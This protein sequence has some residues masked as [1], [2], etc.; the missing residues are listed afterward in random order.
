MAEI[1]IGSYFEDAS[2]PV[3]GLTPT[4]R[5][6]EV[7]VGG[8]ELIIGAPCGTWQ[9]LDGVMS[10]IQECSPPEQDGLYK[11]VFTDTIGYDP[12]KTYIVRVDG[13]NTLPPSFRYQTETIS[14]SDNLSIGNITDGVW[15]AQRSNHLI[16]GST[17]EGLNLIKAD[18]TS[19]ANNL[20]LD[21]D[22][23]LEVVQLLLKLESGRTRI[24]PTNNTLTIFDE[25]CSTP[26]RVFKL[27]DSTG[28]ESVVDVC[29]RAPVTKGP[30]DTTT[31]TDI[32]P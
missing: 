16:P 24:N 25:D 7:A 9:S 13:G 2:G 32:C 11:F 15:N 20:F 27:Y 19:I 8:N 18:T 23:V 21:V 22:S 30:G 6:W 14:P 12:T 1:I 28:A 17:G 10:E 29:E 5:I 31:I 3:V 26:L 4:V